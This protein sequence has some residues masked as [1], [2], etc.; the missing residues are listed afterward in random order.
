L[1]VTAEQVRSGVAAVIK[2]HEAQLKEERW[3]NAFDLQLP[4]SAARA[5]KPTLASSKQQQVQVHAEGQQ[6]HKRR[7]L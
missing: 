4:S 1:Q 6:Q 3:D 5:Q 7:Q 2:A